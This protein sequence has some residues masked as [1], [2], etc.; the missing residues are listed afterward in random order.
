MKSRIAPF[1]FILFLLTALTGCAKKTEPVRREFFSMD[2][3]MQVI[4][5]PDR[6]SD[7]AKMLDL[8]EQE[9]LRT[10]ALLTS[11]M[12]T[13]ERDSAA[14]ILNDSE[15]SALLNRALLISADTDGAFDPTVWPIVDAWGFYS[16]SHRIPK[17][18]ELSALLQTIGWEKARS[19]MNASD[20]DAL[21]K[22]D[23]GAI[24]KGYAASTVKE[25]LHENGVTSAILSLGGNVSLLGSRPDGSDFTVGIRDPEDPAAYFATLSLSDKAVVTSGSYE[26]SFEQDGVRYSHII[27]PKTGHP[28]DN[29][30]LSVTVVAD[31]DILA[32]ALSTA[33]FVMGSD[34][35]AQFYQS[36]LYDFDM[37]L[38]EK[39]RSVTITQGLK[40]CFETAETLKGILK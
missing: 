34:G 36:G 17:E 19:A 32:D 12:G 14:K 40:N 23:L 7:P 10:D 6:D 30:L 16:G 9:V 24:G 11:A 5:Y 1:I 25:K 2:T 31:D 15:L 27:D 38:M 3:V 28:V 20:P 39:D 35:A 21:P 8:A 33:L 18:D 29:S 22:L 13:A 37:I 4:L 26:R